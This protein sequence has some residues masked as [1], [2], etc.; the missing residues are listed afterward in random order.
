[1]LWSNL[2]NRAT[3]PFG[4][5]YKAESLTFLEDAQTDLSLFARCYERD[6]TALATD[7]VEKYIEL[8]SDFIELAEAPICNGVQLLPWEPKGHNTRFNKNSHSIQTGTPIYYSVEGNKMVLVPYPQSTQIVTMRYHAL[9]EKYNSSNVHFNLNYDGL[10]S[11]TFK[12]GDKIKGLTSLITA[13][14]DKNEGNQDKTGTLTIYNMVKPTNWGSVTKIDITNEGDGYSSVPVVHFSGGGGSGATAT[15]V[16]TANKVSAINVTNKGSGYTSAPN[17]TITGGG[18]STQATATADM[19]PTGF[20]NNEDIVVIDEEENAYTGDSPYGLG[21][22]WSDIVTNWDDLGFGGRAK[23]KGTNY[24]ETTET[25]LSP[26]IPGIFHQCLVDYA[27]AKIY[28]MLG[29]FQDS[30]R[31]MG[32]YFQQREQVASIHH[33]KTFVGPMQVADVL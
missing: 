28:E 2:Q 20:M 13:V 25:G 31:A 32:R 24:N 16:V 14:V 26:V 3:L 17:I 5:N 27:Q 7:E 30:D 22:T 19:V 18:Y 8:P 29:D 21:Y 11:Q 1:M 6:F 4:G 10:L 9:A 33:S 12:K 15:A 23:A